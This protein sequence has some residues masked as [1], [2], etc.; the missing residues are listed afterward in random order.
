MQ[1]QFRV[2]ETTDRQYIGMEISV[3]DQAIPGAVTLPDGDEIRIETL[4]RLGGGL[5]RVSNP[6]YIAFISELVNG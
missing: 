5:F 1:R 6:N 2:I 3:D 4:E